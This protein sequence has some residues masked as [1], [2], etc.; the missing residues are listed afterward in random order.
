MKVAVLIL[1]E[2]RE[3]DIAVKSWSFKDF[4]HIDYQISS[5]DI[6]NQG[7]V[8]ENVTEDSFT[9]HLNNVEHIKIWEAK[10]YHSNDTNIDYLKD[11]SQAFRFHFMYM[12]EELILPKNKKYD[13]IF[14]TRPDLWYDI[15]SNALSIPFFK[16]IEDGTIYTLGPI[17]PPTNESQGFVNDILFYGKSKEMIEFLNLVQYQPLNHENAAK[18]IHEN[19]K[20]KTSKTLS[21][22]IVRPNVRNIDDKSKLNIEII[23][24]FDNEFCEYKEKRWNNK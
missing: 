6:S 7:G 3:F 15:D 18:A 23:Q 1:G 19:F 14:I 8:K 5:W 21:A 20:H 22:N 12:Y 10:P 9:K 4:S 2:F 17:K 24:Q 13:Y 11:T 16:Q